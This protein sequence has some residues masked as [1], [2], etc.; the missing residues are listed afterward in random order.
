VIASQMGAGSDQVLDRTGE[1]TSGGYLTVSEVAELARCEH[2]SVRRAIASGLL[3]A[4]RPAHK[5]LIRESDARAWIESRPV[6][7]AAVASEHARRP[8]RRRSRPRP[9]SVDDLLRI[10]REA[11]GR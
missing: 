3:I 9:G 2:K 11:T 10:E 6:V 8:G 5:L 7:V 4:F 1:K